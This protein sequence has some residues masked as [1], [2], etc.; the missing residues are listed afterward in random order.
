MNKLN[1]I[2]SGLQQIIDNID[3]GNSNNSEEELEET[4]DLLT[5]LTSTKLSKY[6]ACR[7]LNI[8]RSTFDKYIKDGKIPE[9]RKEAGFTEKFWYKKDL[10]L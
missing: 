4:V 2:K 3:A 5:R 1:L 10:V 6:Q 7:Y 9:G 8:S